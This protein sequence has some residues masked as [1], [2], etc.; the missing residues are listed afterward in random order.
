VVQAGSVEG[1]VHLHVPSR[2][3]VALPYR[4]GIAPPR[5]VAFQD[6]VDSRLLAQTLDRGDAAA[7]VGE[8]VR[9]GV[10]SGL[11]G[12]GKTQLALDYAE[13]L[14]AAG[15]VDVW[16][17]VTA[18]SR[19]AIVSSYARLATE[20]TGIEDHNPEHGAQ[21][22]LEWLATTP[23][24]WLV[25]V[26]D[27][28]SP[29]DLRG[30]WPPDTPTGRVVVT[31]RRHDAALR[32]PG[33]RVIEVGVFTPDEAH[34][35][36][37]GALAGQPHV[38]D[39]PDDRDDPGDGDGDGVEG[40]ARALGYLPL[41]LAQAAAYMVDR[42]LTCAAYR[43][44]LADRRRRLASLLP[45]GEG[46]PDEHRATVAVTW[47]LSVEQANQLAPAGLADPL[48]AVASVLDAN[49]IPLG[50]FTA[51]AV[52]ELLTAAT[53]REVSGEDAVDGLGCLQRL[54]LITLDPHM[55]A[56]AVRVHALVQRAT[57]DSLPP[58]R[59][60]VMVRAAADALVRV[61]PEIERDATLGQ[62]LRAN[63]EAVAEVGGQHVWEPEAHPVLFRAGRSLGERGGVAQAREYFHRLHAMASERLGPDH[64]DTL[65]TRTNLA[66]WRGLAGD[67]AGAAAALEEL[68]AD[69]LRV[70]G[71]DHPDTLITRDYLALFRAQ[72]GDP[73]GAVT[74]YEELLTD[75]LRVLG[76]DHPDT[77][78]TRNN[79]ASFRGM[80]GDAAGATTAYEELVADYLRVLG[81]DHPDILIAR[82]NLAL[83]RGHVG[84]PT[85]AAAALEKVF[86]DYLR[87]LGPDHPNTLTTRHYLTYWR[88][89]AQDPAAAAAAY[90]ELLTDYQRVLGPDHPNTLITRHYL[91]HWRGEAG[92]P[93]G[94]AAAFEELLADDVRVL[95]PDHPN[96]LTTR[97][98]LT[99]WRERARDPAGAALAFQ[100]LLTDR[101]RVM[102]SNH[103]NPLRTRAHW[104]DRSTGDASP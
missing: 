25:V 32:G 80:A 7:G 21:R 73:A 4:A 104:H 12:V 92:D 61:W 102:G 79:L 98:Y 87:V 62:V 49:G 36:L 57:R 10:V 5:A 3:V 76:P 86:A 78:A 94:A 88:G 27:V 96:T 37:R 101:L 41:A 50:V 83:W 100:K 19:E 35:Y 63:A 26:D 97:H 18:G 81:P 30:L 67:S 45:E 51:T 43:G 77:L 55:S 64:P 38:L 95:G 23:A 22:L 91:A 34:G 14:W 99:Y 84:N 66:H 44:R 2:P 40:L 6:R 74:A 71:P 72:A 68:L 93:T 8:P 70:L 56:R 16:V 103:P 65:L 39:G 11:G 20:L 69:Y 58:D 13:H 53:G 60:A 29:Q 33:R 75:Y 9:A 59:L 1:G 52:L 17:W 89:H 90:E 42:N 85:D 28:Q 15:E 24:R 54:S 31:T 48:L 47:S 82:A 46:L